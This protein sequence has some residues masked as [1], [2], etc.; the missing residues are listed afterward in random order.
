MYMGIGAFIVFL[1]C[2]L[3]MLDI[4]PELRGIA[5][6]GLTSIGVGLAFLGA[7]YVFE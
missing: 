4:V 7:Y 1:S 3:T 2:V 6:Y 5:L